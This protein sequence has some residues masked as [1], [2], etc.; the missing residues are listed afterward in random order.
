MK[1]QFSEAYD[2]LPAIEQ[3]SVR[4]RIMQECG[5]KSF[6]TFYSKKD[7]NVKIRKTEAPVIEGI[8]SEYNINC[9]TGQYIRQFATS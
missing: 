6:P 1:N 8:F 3:T 4:D 2:R 7:G 9:W 5:W